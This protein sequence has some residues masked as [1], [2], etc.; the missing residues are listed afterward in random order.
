MPGCRCSWESISSLGLNRRLLCC[1][2][3]WVRPLADNT[4]LHFDRIGDWRCSTFRASNHKSTRATPGSFAS[5]LYYKSL[6]TDR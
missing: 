3:G 6:H 4:I 1:V 5:A 2:G